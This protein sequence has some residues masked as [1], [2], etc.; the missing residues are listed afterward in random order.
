MCFKTPSVQQRD[1]QAEAA[2]AATDAQ[3]SANA[4]TALM[5]Q[6]RKASALETGAANGALGSP[7]ALQAYNK[8]ALG[9]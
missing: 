5:R 3:V 9:G 2:Q 6:R 7:S 4:Q 8:T 1:P